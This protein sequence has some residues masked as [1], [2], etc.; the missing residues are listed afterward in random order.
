MKC[1]NEFLWTT[2][3]HRSCVLNVSNKACWREKSFIKSYEEVGVEKQG[4]LSPLQSKVKSITQR[5]LFCARFLYQSFLSS[6]HFMN[7]QPVM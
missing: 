4:R 5:T 7:K 2:T 6:L 3:E 1:P